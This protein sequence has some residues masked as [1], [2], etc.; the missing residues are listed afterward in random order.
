MH[1]EYKFFSNFLNFTWNLFC[2]G[3]EELLYHWGEAWSIQY[4]S[5][6]QVTKVFADG[7]A[8]TWC[9]AICNHRNAGHTYLDHPDVMKRAHTS[10]WDHDID[11][12]VHERRNYIA[13]ALELRLS[14]TNPS[15][16]LV[17]C[18]FRVWSML[19]LC[20]CSVVCHIVQYWAMLWK[21][22]VSVYDAVKVILSNKNVMIYATVWIK[23]HLVV[24]LQQLILTF[25][26]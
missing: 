16:W 9:Q 10:L 15:I 11:G 5:P 6:S 13:N 21:Q 1:F 4:Y 7:L 12:L 8:P 3:A 24:M 26:W 17:F 14:C 23:Q 22:H 19:Y 18:E 2:P 25:P 20:Y